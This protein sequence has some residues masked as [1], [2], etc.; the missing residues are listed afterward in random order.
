MCKSIPNWFSSIHFSKV[1]YVMVAPCCHLY[2]PRFV[3]C[4]KRG[5]TVPRASRAVGR[6]TWLPADGK[7]PPPWTMG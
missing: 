2:R 7:T 4:I 3:H 6:R 5:K 1:E